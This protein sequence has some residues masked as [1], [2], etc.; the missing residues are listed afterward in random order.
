ML[1][2]CIPFNLNIP[3]CR[4]STFSFLNVDVYQKTWSKV[5]RWHDEASEAPDW[6]A[7]RFFPHGSVS[8]RG[9]PTATCW[10][11]SKAQTLFQHPCWHSVSVKSAIT[12]LC[13]CFSLLSRPWISLVSVCLRST[14]VFASPVSCLL[15]RPPC[16]DG[17]SEWNPKLHESAAACL[18]PL[19]PPSAA[20]SWCLCIR[21]PL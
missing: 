20:A 4:L 13:C 1:L 11:A 12:A 17:P 10:A 19:Q 8:S 15:P 18:H 2:F 5:W 16:S 21:I 9:G 7:S 3:T 14:W 6:K